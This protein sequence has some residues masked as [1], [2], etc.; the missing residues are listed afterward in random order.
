MLTRL[1]KRT[2]RFIDNFITGN[3]EGE[4]EQKEQQQQTFETPESIPLFIHDILVQSISLPEDLAGLILSYVAQYSSHHSETHINSHGRNN[5]DSLYAALTVPIDCAY[6]QRLTI[7]AESHDQGNSDEHS[8]LFHL[9]LITNFFF[10]IVVLCSLFVCLGWASDRGASYSWW[11]VAILDEKNQ[12]IPET[13]RQRIFE[14]KIAEG[15]FQQHQWSLEIPPPELEINP[16]DAVDMKDPI[17]RSG[18]LK[19]LKPGYS[20]GLYKRSLYPGKHNACSICYCLFS[21]LSLV[22][23]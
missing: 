9:L 2:R 4:S 10:L 21:P 12:E 3:D 11:D 19:L 15:R 6:I 22:V 23:I 5:E 1:A 16:Y 13:R 17:D 7:Q 14:N 8:F 20:V 18:W